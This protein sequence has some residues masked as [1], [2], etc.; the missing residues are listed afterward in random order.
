MNFPLRLGGVTALLGLS[1]LQAPAAH[2]HGAPEFPIARVYNCYK[3]PTLP[4]CQ[5]AVA[6]GG[7]QALYDWNGV[8]QGQAHG[9][10]QAVVPNLQLCAGGQEKFKGFDLARA[11]WVATP[12]SPGTDGQYEFRYHASAPHRTLNWK[13]Y[14]TRDGFN[15]TASPLRWSDLDQVAELGPNQMVTEGNRYTMR[16][17]L[18]KRTG[19]H[20]L[21]SIWQRSDSGEAFYG[22]SDVD[23]GGGATPP[24]LPS[25]LTQIGQ[26]S[27]AQ[28]LPARSLV[29]LRVFDRQ[30]A[31]L[32]TIT[33]TLTSATPPA[34]WLTQIAT[35]VNQRSAYVQVGALQG[36][37]VT[38]PSGL[39]V[40]DVY[41]RP[42]ALGVTHVLDI[43][44]PATTTP[45]STT[46]PAAGSDSGSSTKAWVEGDGYTVGQIVSF[47]GQRYR[48]LQAHTAWRGAGWTPS[49]AGVLNVLWQ[50]VN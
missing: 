43:V 47:Q 3:N 29:K 44:L 7:A 48:C 15:P 38:V 23:F 12:W 34:S 37:Q 16:L 20:V 11:D 13:F 9:N 21:Y 46:P 32:E 2:A 8:N 17:T 19:K 33:L 42:A 28:T 30:G 10:H 1:I 25:A 40:M 50:P 36:G 24:S 14:L 26:V 45:P 5:A 18:P 35:L 27:A 31:D 41:A 22:C 4:A 6:A 49:A 39:T